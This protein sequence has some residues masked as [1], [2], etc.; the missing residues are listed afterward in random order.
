MTLYIEGFFVFGLTFS[1]TP[2]LLPELFDDWSWLDIPENFPQTIVLLIS[3][4]QLNIPV[5]VE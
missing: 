4:D 1:M 2:V 3:D 5:V